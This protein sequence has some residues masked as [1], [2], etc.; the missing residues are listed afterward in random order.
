MAAMREKI[1]ANAREPVK[2][3]EGGFFTVPKVVE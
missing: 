1:L 2:V 3:G